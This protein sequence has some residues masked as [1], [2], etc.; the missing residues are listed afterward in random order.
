MMKPHL[1]ELI[2]FW[3][4]F[5]VVGL[6]AFAVMSPYLTAIFLASVLSILFS[7]FHA[8]VRKWTKGNDTAA[9]LLT[10]L[11]IFCLILIPLIFLVV[12]MSQEVLSI[13]SALTYKNG[14][15]A[16]LDHATKF[17][18]RQIQNFNPSFE[19][20][21]GIYTYLET[22]L[23]WVAGNLDALLSGILSF[24][25]QLL[26]VLISMFFFYRDGEKLHNFIVKW[27]PL[28]DSYD[29]GIIAKLELAVSSVIKGSLATAI[30]QG[31]L[32]GVGFAL[33]GVPNPVLWGMVATVTS[34]IPVIGTGAVLLPAVV[35]LFLGGNVL[36]GGGLLLWGVFLVGLIDN[37]T[38]PFF[39]RRGM[40]IHPFLIFLS[41][42]GGLAYFGPIG[43]L[44]GPIVLAFFFALLDI[45]P[46]IVKGREI[47]GAETS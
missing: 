38:R 43:F 39:M 27:S 8:Y 17:F 28:S 47:D 6:L 2:F 14:G 16:F 11:L 15:F 29:E 4:L 5:A 19:L 45:Y 36:S 9:A 30:I 3:M 26:L 34:L 24:A 32:L 23:R 21:S 20:H 1:G 22:A 25:S 33:F 13:Y 37:I 10:V 42:L 41:V 44:T 31:V 7:P 46:D 40:D 18:E 35:Y 12:L